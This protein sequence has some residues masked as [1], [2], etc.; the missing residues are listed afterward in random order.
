MSNIRT[1]LAIE[2][3]EIYQ[4]DKKQ[5]IPGVE[6]KVEK[7]QDINI[8]NVKVLDYRGEQII[9]KPIG[10][11]ITIEVPKLRDRDKELEKEVSHVLAQQL[12]KLDKLK[13]NKAKVLVV[14]LG[15][16]NITPDA[17]GP[18]VVSNLL[19]T[20]H[21]LELIP[22]KL[23]ERLKP[24]C[25]MAPGVLGITGIETGEIIKG[26]VEKVGPTVVV[27]I[28]ALASRKT[29][30]LNTTIQISDS[31]INPGSG[32]GNRRMAL[33]EET[34]KVPVIGIGVPTVVNAATIVNDTITL[35]VKALKNNT[36]PDSSFFKIL[37]KMNENDKT[38]LINEVLTPYIGNLM[39][40][41]KEIDALIDD[42]SKI[43]ADGINMSVHQGMSL[44]EINTY[45]NL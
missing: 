33:T 34:L 28:D 18:K 14:G 9:N 36:S 13:E 19:I 1:D 25:G 23:D 15:N 8:T 5:E 38:S 45:I 21:M 3:R 7:L 6:V 24:V 10:T 31:G 42:V 37:D 44:E 17:L 20:R 29:E 40:T 43:I 16:W 11:Y 41:P 2:A 4:E 30:R 22:D 12:S 39:V 27:A 26:I 35:L 32:V